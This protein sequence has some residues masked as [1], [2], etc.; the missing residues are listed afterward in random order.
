MLMI[1]SCPTR[2][3]P[4]KG[5]Q[6]GRVHITSGARLQQRARLRLEASMERRRAAVGLKLRT[7]EA[8]WRERGFSL[9]NF[10][11]L[12]EHHDSVLCFYTK[13]N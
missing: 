8:V 10:A 5:G 11:L 12:A 3:I 7:S 1:Y 4:L 2:R 6:D 13:D 9:G